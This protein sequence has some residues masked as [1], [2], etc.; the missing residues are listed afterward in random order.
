MTR[1]LSK[2]RLAFGLLLALLGLIVL[3][4][5]A[6]VMVAATTE[7]GLQIVAQRLKKVGRVQ[8]DARGI[9]GSLTGGFRIASLTID[10]P[11]VHLEFGDVEGRAAVLPLMW[12]TIELPRV[13]ARTALIQVHPAPPPR[14]GTPRWPRSGVR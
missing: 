2:R 14:P 3:L 12:Q 8:I 11:R 6:L 4:P 5:T 10:H 13:Q 7:T 9:E 1:P